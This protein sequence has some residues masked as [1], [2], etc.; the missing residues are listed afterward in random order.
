MA[1]HP[2]GYRMREPVL[3]AEHEAIVTE[4]LGCAIAVHREL[5]PGFREHVYHRAM[6]LELDAQG[7]DFVSEKQ[8][9]IKYK[10]WMIPGH[11]LTLSS[12]MSC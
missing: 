7:I 5:G 4:T 2:L 12:G 10:S 8:I 6:C 1:M 11:G 9:D 3:P